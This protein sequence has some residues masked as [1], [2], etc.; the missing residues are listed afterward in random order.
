MKV[1]FH[2]FGC[3]A[4]QYD[5]AIV[6]QAFADHGATAVD[7][8]AGA[9]LAVLNSCTVTAAGEAKL[10]TLARR[11][12]RAR[13]DTVVMGCAAAVD[14]GTIAAVPGVRAVVAGADADA[15]LRAAGLP[16]RR[17]A[18]GLRHFPGSA[19]AWLRIQDGCDEHCT[20]CATTI[21]RGA[22]R[23]RPVAELVAEARALAEH[24]AEIVI[25]GIHI[26][27]YGQDREPALT[28]HNA[29]RTLG[30]LL[31]ALID[32][33]PTVRFR[34]SSIEATEIDER[35]ERLL[36][37]APR[38]L[39]AHVHAPLQ[40]G[41]DRVL[42]RMGR[43]WYTAARYRARLEHLAARLPAFGLG[44][45]IMVGFPGETAADHRAT[46]DLIAALPFTYLHVF[47]Y[48]PR[49]GTAA[50]RLG[51]AVGS[52]AARARAAELRALGAAK[53]DA[54]RA[55]RRGR[56]ADGVACGHA[57]GRV[58]VLTEDYLTVYLESDRW[59]GTPRLDVTID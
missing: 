41:S 13:V 6:R 53:G 1:Y 51:P 46:V 18:P 39:A 19:R 36:V 7:D 2:T 49:P 57:G 52:A 55:G 27:T 50:P 37:E 24:H 45:D 32:A 44:A 10:R 29:P 30:A 58:D 8:P 54:Y 5:T 11:L 35:L 22:N 23:S 59:D 21:A 34:L 3:K 56:R 43:H 20:F 9:D 42:R 38:H 48:S 40:S 25:T 15:V 28:T 31:E 14:D 4:N 16:A 47:P 26:G 17:P 33:V 12:A